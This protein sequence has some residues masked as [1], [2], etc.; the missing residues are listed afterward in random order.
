[1]RLEV[2]YLNL[3]LAEVERASLTS[4]KVILC[5]PGLSMAKYSILPIKI[6]ELKQV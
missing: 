1:M 4:G 6:F 2:S 5:M 3:G